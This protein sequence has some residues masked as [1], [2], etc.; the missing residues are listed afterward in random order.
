MSHAIPEPQ[1]NAHAQYHSDNPDFPA[2]LIIFTLFIG[3]FFG[4]LNDTLLNVALT[5]I[6]ADFHIDKTT[7]QWLTT[8]FLLVMGAFTPITAGLIQWMETRRMVL[9]TQ[10]VFLIGSWRGGCSKPFP[11][12]CSCR[13]CLTPSSPSIR[14]TNAA[15]PWAS[16]P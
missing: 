2:K 5:K 13:F 7:V 3:A 14:R 4:Y 1:A 12:R 8:G 16:S 6:M 11:P 15:A 9:I 10:A